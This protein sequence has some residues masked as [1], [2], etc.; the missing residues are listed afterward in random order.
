MDNAPIKEESL[1]STSKLSEVP[2]NG[3]PKIYTMIFSPIDESVKIGV[4]IIC[5]P[6]RLAAIMSGE[7][8]AHA[9]GSIFFSVVAAI[10]A[11]NIAAP[12]AEKRRARNSFVSTSN[13]TWRRK[14]ECCAV[15]RQSRTSA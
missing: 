3:E 12:F 9:A 15:P 8:A 13:V 10:A 7:F 6:K 14:S 11:T 4:S 5:A 1:D 2:S